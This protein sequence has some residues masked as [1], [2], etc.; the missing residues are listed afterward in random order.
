MMRNNTIL[1]VSLAAV[2]CVGCHVGLGPD[3]NPTVLTDSAGNT[4]G[5]DCD[6]E[7]CSL[8]VN[9]VNIPMP[10]CSGG[11]SQSIT[12]SWGRLFSFCA[13]C[14]S[15]TASVYGPEMCR[16]MACKQDWDC[17]Q[18][19][20]YLEKGN[21]EYRCL[22]GLCQNVDTETYPPKKLDRTLTRSLCFAPYPR[23]E[24]TAFDSPRTVQ[25]NEWVQKYCQDDKNCKLPPNCWQPW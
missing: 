8:N 3:D 23:E 24:T 25:I 4:F 12:T 9:S 18:V 14:A 2:C 20:W 16:P 17:P 15:G 11:D 13:S 10:S 21:A 22:K 7:G 19:Y 1:A 5:W 6:D